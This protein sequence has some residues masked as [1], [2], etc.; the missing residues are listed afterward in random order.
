MLPRQYAAVFV[1][2]VIGQLLAELILLPIGQ[3]FWLTS[4]YDWIGGLLT[5]PGTWI[6]SVM[7]DYVRRAA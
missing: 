5:L 3:R 4:R 7:R 1:G 2:T 6:G